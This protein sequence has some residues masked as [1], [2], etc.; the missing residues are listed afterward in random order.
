MSMTTA[1]AIQNQ[2]QPSR[3]PDRHRIT[4]MSVAK[5]K[6]M[7]PSSGQIQV[8][9]AASTNLGRANHTMSSPMRG[10][11]AENIANRHPMTGSLD[12]KSDPSGGKAVGSPC[13]MARYCPR[14]GRCADG[15]RVTTVGGSP[16]RGDRRGPGGSRGT[17]K[18]QNCWVRA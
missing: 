3:P 18:G 6:K 5:G 1:N 9:N 17:L 16:D 14:G 4:Y 8:S 10:K 15:R 12:Q 2:S 11:T 13:Q 7:M